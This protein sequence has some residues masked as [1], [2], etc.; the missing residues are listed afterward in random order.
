MTILIVMINSRSIANAK[1]HFTECIDSAEAG[2][3]V[4]IT[5]HGKPVAAIVRANDL[6]AL[7][8]LHDDDPKSGLAGILGA[9]NDDEGL[10]NTLD[11]IVKR[12][13]PPRRVPA[14]K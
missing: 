6:F 14:L 1:A 10:A 4:M 2:E 9:W 13:A 11:A 3:P 12:R 7:S 8:Q 5:R